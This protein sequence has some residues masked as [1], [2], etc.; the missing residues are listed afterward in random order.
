MRHNISEH[1][2]PGNSKIAFSCREI[3]APFQVG[4]F[5]KILISPRKTLKYLLLRTDIHVYKFDRKKCESDTVGPGI[6][7][8]QSA[9]IITY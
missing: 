5:E 4:K 8:H 3:K 1:I 7:S 6:L 9:E 2:L